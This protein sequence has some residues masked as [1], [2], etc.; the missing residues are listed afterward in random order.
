MFHTS[1]RERVAGQDQI[2]Q[3]V[4]TA[5]SD[6][7]KGLLSAQGVQTEPYE[8]P[9]TPVPATVPRHE[10]QAR[11]VQTEPSTGGSAV[12]LAPQQSVGWP[13]GERQP[14]A[15]SGVQPGTDEEEDGGRAP[16]LVWA[17]I[18]KRCAWRQWRTDNAKAME[19][20]ARPRTA[21]DKWWDQAMLDEG[22][23]RHTESAIT[24]GWSARED[25]RLAFGAYGPLSVV[26]RAFAQWRVRSARGAGVVQVRLELRARSTRLRCRPSFELLVRR[27]RRF[28]RLRPHPEAVARFAEPRARRAEWACLA[29]W[30]VFSADTVHCERWVAFLTRRRRERQARR[31]FSLLCEAARRSAELARH[32][33]QRHSSEA[34]AT[35]A[36]LRRVCP[37]LAR[38]EA[39]GALARRVARQAGL[40]R[41]TRRWR[42]EWMTRDA[43]AFH[44]RARTGV[45]IAMRLR[46][47]I[48]RALAIWTAAARA[49]TYRQDAVWHLE[50]I[51]AGR[52]LRRASMVLSRFGVECCSSRELLSAAAAVLGRRH[53]GANGP[54]ALTRAFVAWS[55]M[56]RARAATD[57]LVRAL[58]ARRDRGEFARRARREFRSARR[59]FLRWSRLVAICALVQQTRLRVGSG[60]TRTPHP[61]RSAHS[62]PRLAASASYVLLT[63]PLPT[64]DSGTA[65]AVSFV[66]STPDTVGLSCGAPAESG[67]AHRVERGSGEAPAIVS[68][69]GAP[70][71]SHKISPAVQAAGHVGRARCGACPSP[72]SGQAQ[73]RAGSLYRIHS[74][75][76]FGITSFSTSWALVAQADEYLAAAGAHSRG[77]G[78]GSNGATAVASHPHR[79]VPS[80]SPHKRLADALRADNSVR[81]AQQRDRYISLQLQRFRGS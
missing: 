28:R 50:R 36:F 7:E 46:A 69:D 62:G 68:A 59:G 58:Q 15:E 44:R 16:R 21:F 77:C 24:A 73:P 80:A 75:E 78:G 74:P 57:A 41:A 31:G 5:S 6:K 56:R 71:R 29:R 39:M 35:L 61:A 9:Y 25:H 70:C 18:S 10:Q 2:A 55:L 51:R 37:E 81:R 43:Q 12:L 42:G 47:A 1:H 32:F 79:S 54:A 67:C 20:V 19:V 38:R 26:R 14:A 34:R 60:G 17:A 48:M 3:G 65:R 52:D 45:A 33:E 66:Q 22:K 13:A 23:A 30:L 63:R 4:Q 27:H 72:P 11:G 64:G 53:L 40:T 49:S 76:P 8:D